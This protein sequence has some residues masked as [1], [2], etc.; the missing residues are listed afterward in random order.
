MLKLVLRAIT[1]RLYKV[2][3]GIWFFSLK[4]EHL[5]RNMSEMS[6]HCLLL[7][8]CVCLVK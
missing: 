1:S 2:K 8:L 3:T 6:L 4:M 7:M 5:S